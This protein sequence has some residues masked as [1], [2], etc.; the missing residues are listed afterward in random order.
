MQTEQTF[1][2]NDLVVFDMANNHQ[3][4]VE[5]GTR[6]VREFGEVARKHGV[7]AGM[8]FQFRQL[9]SF[10]H[11][12]HREGSKNK[13]IPRFLSTR[14]DRGQYEQLKREVDKAGLLSICTP[15]DEESVG[16][17]ADMGFDILKIASCSATDWPLLERAAASNLPVICST[18]GLE[19]H[20]IDDLYSFFQHKGADFAFMHCVSIY[21]TPAEHLQL[22]QIDLFRRRYPDITVGWSTHEDQDALGPVQIAYAKGARMFER[23]VGVESGDI[24][25]NAYS[26]RPEQADRWLAALRDARSMCGSEQRLPATDTEREALASLQRGVYVKES[27]PAGAELTRNMVYFSMPIEPGQLPSGQFRPGIRTTREIAEDGAILL[28]SVALPPPAPDVVIKKA[29][30]EVKAML[31][32][33]GVLLNTDFR[34]EYSHHYGVEKFREIGAVLIDIV[35]RD[36]CKKIIVQLPGQVHPQH[37]HKLK[38]ETFQVLSGVLN[39][40]IEGRK[41]VLHPGDTCLIQ[42]GMWHG[43]WTETGCVFEEISTKHYNDDSFYKDKNINAMKRSDRK[44]V[45]NHWG[46]YE[47]PDKLRAAAAE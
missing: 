25:L 20:Q 2:F 1:D 44:T 32:E 47:L 45:V 29:I 7:R 43:F 40:V 13:H 4:S 35:N 5:H 22:N 3:G 9:D 15:F 41:R 27:V 38:E 26:S 46:R 21:P 39:V 14:L 11:P 28:D 17:I 8:K 23:H 10:I 33:A 24:R 19:L 30:H 37:F 12:S 6:I 42:P 18:G 31:H 34:I 16:I 36:Y